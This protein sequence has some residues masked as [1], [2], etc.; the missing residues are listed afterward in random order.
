HAQSPPPAAA[1]TTVIIQLVGQSLA[2]TGNTFS[3]QDSLLQLAIS[4]SEKA[5]RNDYRMRLYHLWS[6]LKQQQSENRL[7]VNYGIQAVK[8]AQNNPALQA[9]I[10]YRDA[11]TNLAIS[12][13]YID[14]PD[15]SLYWALVGKNLSGDKDLFNYSVLLSI[16]AIVNAVKSIP[17]RALV[18]FDSATNMARSTSNPHDDVM[19]AFNKAEFLRS[20][21]EKDWVKSV[22]LLTSMQSL[23]DH[24][25][26][27]NFTSTPHLRMPFF[28]RKARN[29]LYHNLSI[30][31]FYLFD[32]ED[33]SYY[34]NLVV[35]NYKNTNNFTYL[36]YPWT[37][38]AEIETFRGN[39]KL[40]KHIYD[41]SLHLIKQNTNRETIPYP[42]FFYTA[43][44]LAEQDQEY[45]RAVAAYREAM[46]LTSPAITHVAPAL[47][48]GYVKA[49]M[50]NE[51]D[52]LI[53]NLDSKLQGSEIYVTILYKKELSGY[54]L[55][56]G[57]SSKASKYLLEFYRL[58]DSLTTAGRYYMVQEVETRFKTREKEKQLF[59]ANKEK[60]LQRQQ[61]AQRK[62]GIIL[63]TVGIVVLLVLITSLYRIY[64]SK[65][66]QTILLAQK[67]RQIETL[68]REL[69]H[70]VKNNLQVVSSLLSLQSDKLEDETARR[71]LEEGKT[72]VDAMAMIHHKLYMDQDLNSVDIQ[73]YLSSLLLSLANSFGY[74]YE[75]VR[76]K[77]K[78]A[79]KTLHIDLAIPIGLIV[80]ELVTNAFK[81]AFKNTADP[82]VT[83]SLGKTADGKLEFSVADNGMG[84]TT[85]PD[86]TPSF[87]MKLVYTLVN[88]LN[89]IMEMK[90]ENGTIYII[91]LRDN[92]T[93]D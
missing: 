20:S 89:G 75:H 83:V 11:V 2:P 69:H 51:A 85:E 44:W 34:L 53:A 91:Q 10:S 36:P 28:Y 15:S 4:R 33:A 41:S 18:L 9:N 58:K 82:L 42:S 59:L 45:Q 22:E 70:R 17:A 65:H 90:R 73:D 37:M 84:V 67:N 79:Q 77:V 54:H 8:S 87:G 5:G 23:I 31:Y 12:Y 92:N 74:S 81:H 93:Y 3:R 56:K 35:E 32:L 52:S 25:Q 24:P 60:L 47:L 43:G 49:G 27:N 62:D 21:G 39:R 76:T 61:L 80:N 29:T 55:K 13:L 57:D 19:A 63:L 16:E 6:F 64:R 78:L 68:I 40:V 1:D 7:A 66:R 71:A 26:L 88:Q 38:L 14:K 46:A 48:R 86:S 50:W 30:A 72:R